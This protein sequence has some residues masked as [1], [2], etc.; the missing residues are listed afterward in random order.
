M[1]EKREERERGKEP[2]ESKTRKEKTHEN[3]PRNF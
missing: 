3:V 1:R 2:E